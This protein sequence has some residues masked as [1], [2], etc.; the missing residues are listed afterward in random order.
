MTRIARVSLTNYRQYKDLTVTFN[1]TKEHDLHLIVAENGI[2]KTTLLNSIN[3]CLYKKEP[4]I[5]LKQ[6]ALTLLNLETYREMK[7][8][9]VAEIKVEIEVETTAGITT[10]VRTSSMRRTEED[11][12]KPYEIGKSFKII[13]NIVGQNT[14]VYVGK[15]T[16]KFVN[17][18]IPWKIKQFF[19]LDGEQMDTYFAYETGLRVEQ[20]VFGISQIDVLSLMA[21]NLKKIDTDKRRELGRNN[22]KVDEIN[23][24]LELC[25]ISIEELDKTLHTS[26]DELGVAITELKKINDEIGDDPDVDELEKRRN[27]LKLLIDQLEEQKKVNTTD[28]QRLIKRYTMLF[29]SL[30]SFK[31]M[32]DKIIEMENKK[33]LPLQI[34]YDVI[35]SMLADNTCA[36]CGNPLQ[37]NALEKVKA[38]RDQHGKDDDETGNVLTSIKGNIISAIKE[39]KA[40]EINRDK[41]LAAIK[42]NDEM[43]DKLLIEEANIEREVGK[44]SNRERIKELYAKRTKFE[45]EKK[46]KDELIVRTKVSLE[47]LEKE[48]ENLEK[49]LKRELKKDRQHTLLKVEKEITERAKEI[50][51]RVIYKIKN[52][53][54]E[55]ISDEMKDIFF[56]LLWKKDTFTN[57]SLNKNYM[58]SLL[59]QDGF[60]CLGSCS[61]AERELLALS[62]TL[63]LHK[64]SG[65]DGPLVIDTPISR[66]SGKLR[67]SFAEVLR[68]VSKNKQVVL[69]LTED[70]YSEQ[71]Q[72]KF[73]PYKSSKIE[74]SLIDEKYIKVRCG[75][76]RN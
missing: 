61:A 18:F 42:V 58:I 63:A 52:G 27:E 6:H 45:E 51:E 34:P 15:E 4:H 48:K 25:M 72:A 3:W 37:G 23:G 29:Y 33:Q 1:R 71:V 59:N 38:L 44:Y 60:E 46:A 43:L 32:L 14:K 11:G 9:E 22:P 41:I 5:T 26:I 67:E 75:N 47:S 31:K 56:N 64:E 7:V 66:I 36:V 54:R 55:K 69:Y 35:I 57:V 19:F 30:P 73:E 20:A 17:Q 40:Y 76:A 24:Q 53:I 74:L 65:F 16:D 50:S 13:N 28:L 68:D 2:G 21:D 10:F 70:E 39:A 49:K 12:E 8:G 62:F